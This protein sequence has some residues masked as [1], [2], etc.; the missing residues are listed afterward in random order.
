MYCLVVTDDYSRF[1]WV[2]FLAT[3]DETSGILKSFIT[4][5]ENLID[6]KV[7]AEAVSTACYVQN[8]MLVVKPHNKTPYELFHGRTPTLSFMRPFGCLVSILSTIDHLG[9]FDGKV[10]EGLFVG[11]SFNSKAF[12]VFNNRTRIVKENLHIS[13]N[14]KKADED[15]RKESECED[16]EKEDNV[17]KTNNVN[18]IGNVNTISS[19]VNA[20]GT[21]E[22]NVVGGKISIELPFDLKMPTLEDDSIF[23]FLNDDENDDAVADINNLDTTIQA[24]NDFSG[25][26]RMEGESLFKVYA[27]FKDFVVYQMDVKSA[28]LYRKIEEE[29]YVCQPPG[30]EDLDF[31]D[32]VYKVEKVLYGLHQA[33][34]AWYETLSTYPLDNGFQR[35]KMTRP[36]SSKVAKSTAMAKTINEEAQLHALVDVKEIIITESSVRRDLQLADEKDEA[37]NEELGNSLVRATTTASSLEAEHDSGNINKTQSKGEDKFPKDKKEELKKE[38]MAKFHSAILLSVTDEVLRE[39]VDQMTASWL[40]DKLTNVKD[41]LDTFNRIILDLQRFGVKVDNEDQALILL[42]SLL[43]SY[44][45]FVDTMLYGRT[46]ISVNDVKDALISKELNRK[47]LGMR[48]LVQ[49]CLQVW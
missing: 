22:V 34:R 49:A 19:T 24:L 6:H 39:V 15:S 29:V 37:V 5:I 35:W 1:T 36:Y 40:W 14:G 26:K 4:R 45:N 44:E 43:G 38:I 42:C 9:K 16:Q 12:R 21:N 31:P 23:D 28:F 10:D 8:K 25:I 41:H 48:V 7:E 46:T 30:F 2:F 27:S 20:P 11:Y 13:D 18:T 33:P 3:K 32:R 47:V 17:N